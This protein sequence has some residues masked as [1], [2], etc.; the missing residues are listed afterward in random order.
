ML[1]IFPGPSWVFL[2]KQVLPTQ[3]M[4]FLAAG[5][6]RNSFA[7]LR[8]FKNVLET[9]ILMTMQQ[10]WGCGFRSIPPAVMPVGSP[11]HHAQPHELVLIVQQAVSDSVIYTEFH[12]PDR[13]QVYLGSME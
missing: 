5:T 3:L 2:N 13:L 11:L 12:L 8:S 7:N 10:H 6:Y 4:V 9:S 1:T